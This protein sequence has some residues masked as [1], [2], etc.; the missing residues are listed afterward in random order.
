MP[1]LVVESS[2]LMIHP[3][4]AES[5]G[6]VLLGL[7][8]LGIHGAASAVW[9]EASWAFFCPIV[10][11][12]SAFVQKFWWR[13]GT[14]VS[15]NVDAGVYSPDG[16]L[17]LSTGSTA[18][19]VVNAMQ[20]VD[21]TDKY[22]PAGYYYIALSIDNITGTTFRATTA[23]LYSNKAAGFASMSTAF[24]LPTSATLATVSLDYIPI[25]GLAL[26]TLL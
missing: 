15:G 24:P 3:W 16:T 9:P 7:D 11:P 26:K 14:V 20:S 22:L 25:F 19:A 18:Q 17:L 21:T 23:Q 10:V 2:S 5:C 4:S 8:N 6:E 13:N 1:R 12:T